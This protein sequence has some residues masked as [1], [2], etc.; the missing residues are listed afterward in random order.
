MSNFY[1]LD[2]IKTEIRKQIKIEKAKLE[3]WKKVTFPTKK[4]GSSFK[5]MS[6]NISG[7]RIFH[8]EYAL[9]PNENV[10][11][12]GFNVN[13]YGWHTDEIKLYELIKYMKDEAKKAKTINY[14]PEMRMLERIYIY[15]L[16]DIKEAVSKHIARIEN[17]I[18]TLKAELEASDTAYNAFKN[19]F[20][21]AI[22]ELEVNTLKENG[23]ILYWAILDTIK[24][25]FPFC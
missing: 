2:G 7:A 8:E 3:A 5:I 25:R 19:A 20:G 6:K 4:D 22:K 21:K 18:A 23:Q 16:D 15:D 9:Q 11:R 13:E 24:N 10:L 14:G 12:V 17:A 1:N